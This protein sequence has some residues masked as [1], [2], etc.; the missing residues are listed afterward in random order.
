MNLRIYAKKIEFVSLENVL[1]IY[2]QL[3]IYLYIYCARV[4]MSVCVYCVVSCDLPI[5]YCIFEFGN[6]V[7][8]KKI[9][10]NPSVPHGT[11]TI[12]NK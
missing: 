5:A 1:I 6:F 8:S 12:P 3:N 2:A 7:E 11:Q 4:L 10:G 9:I